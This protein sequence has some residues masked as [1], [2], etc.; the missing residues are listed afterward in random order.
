MIVFLALAVTLF[1]HVGIW[2]AAYNQMNSMNLPRAVKKSAEFVMICATLVVGLL[3]I[4]T[5][6]PIG[7]LEA[8]SFEGIRASALG[9]YALVCWMFA[10]FVCVRG[11]IWVFQLRQP[12][13]FL[14]EEG[15]RI[16]VANEIGRLPTSD[17][18]TRMCAALP[19][20]QIFEFEMTQK[21]FHIEDLPRSFDGLKIAH[22]SDLHMTGRIDREF[23]EEAVARANKMQPDLVVITGDIIDKAKCLNWIDPVFKKLEPRLGVFYVLGNHDRRIKDEKGLRKR[24][25]QAGMTATNSKWVPVKIGNGK[26]WIAGNELPWYKGAED[27]A[28]SP[29]D[30]DPKRDTTLLLSHSPDQFGWACKRDF[31][32][33]LAGHTHGGQIRIPMIG[34]IVSP[35]RYGVKFASGVF[36]AGKTMMHVSRGLSGVHPLRWNCRPEISLLTLRSEQ[37][38]RQSVAGDQQAQES[39]TELHEDASEAE[40]ENAMATKNKMTTKKTG[41]A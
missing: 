22:M 8:V 1:G 23:Y 2:V 3:F 7:P 37:T 6:Y 12:Q 17:S 36:K 25:K 30:F 15:E 11:L 21:E 18:T 29:P 19:G 9:G 38:S 4:A 35:S 24:L 13:S 27:L 33:V 31:R 41:A 20:N 5:R 34:P 39:A 16:N 32:L 28:E 14:N 40:R 10:G 26:L